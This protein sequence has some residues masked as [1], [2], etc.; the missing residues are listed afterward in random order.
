MLPLS[1]ATFEE[2]CRLIHRLCGLFLSSDKTYLIHHRLGPLVEELGLRSYEELCERARLPGWHAVQE[3]VVEAIT[4]HET[5][6]FRDGHP[7]EALRQVLLPDLIEAAGR[8]KRHLGAPPFARLWCAGA[9]TGQ[10]VYSVVLLLDEHLERDRFAGVRRGDLTILA[11]DVCRHV[12][13]VGRAGTYPE[14]E[15]L[16]TV[17]APLVARGFEKTAAG[18]RVRDTLR[19]LVEFRRLNLVDGTR[20]LSLF[21]LILCRN[22]LIYFDEPTRRRIC[23]DFFDRLRPGG[24]LLLGAAENLYGIHDAFRSERHG[25]TIFYRKPR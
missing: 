22:V 25:P 14:A 3:K 21:D 1:L 20:N 15:V 16:R 7:F 6:F 2:L 17:S 19:H 24:V 10:E 13:A 18:Y 5:S 8:R 12:L 4:T 9:S 23:A 11:T